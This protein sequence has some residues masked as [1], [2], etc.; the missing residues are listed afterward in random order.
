[1]GAGAAIR[2]AASLLKHLS[3][4]ADGTTFTDAVDHFEAGMRQRGSEVLTLAMKTVRW[5]L[6]TDTTLGAAATAVSTPILAAV[7]RLRR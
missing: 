4:A 6:A 1:M 7:A 5:I 2:D 3:D